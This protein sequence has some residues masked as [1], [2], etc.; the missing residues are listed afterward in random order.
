MGLTLRLGWVS[1]I[2]VPVAPE[3]TD[4]LALWNANQFNYPILR[5][6]A[7]DYMT[8]RARSVPAEFL[9]WNSFGYTREMLLKLLTTLLPRHR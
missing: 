8:V 1:L 5:M 6:M 3:G 7:R 2:W 4:D 9:I